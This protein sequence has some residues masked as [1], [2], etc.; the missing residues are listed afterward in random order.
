ME[1]QLKEIFT[2]VFDE[3]NETEIEELA[4]ESNETWD[5]WMHLNIITQIEETFN[6]VIIEEK[7]PELNTYKKIKE[8]LKN[9]LSINE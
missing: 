2:S 3:L 9:L 1:A 6:V 5:S 4:A 8:E 7:V